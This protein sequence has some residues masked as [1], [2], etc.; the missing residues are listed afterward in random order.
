MLSE[1]VKVLWAENRCELT[2]TSLSGYTHD[3]KLCRG[4]TQMGSKLRSN[5]IGAPV[6]DNRLTLE[7]RKT[8]HWLRLSTT[9]RSDNAMTEATKLSRA[10]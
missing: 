7:Q 9:C 5:R 8:G 2:D 3:S 10:T 6:G 1:L 4:L